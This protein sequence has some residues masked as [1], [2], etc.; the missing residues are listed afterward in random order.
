M[1]LTE[2]YDLELLEQRRRI[3]GMSKPK[4]AR[5]AGMSA[6]TVYSILE[7]GTGREAGVQKMAQALGISMDQVVIRGREIE[8][9]A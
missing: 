5:L 9:T 6:A 8:R 7:G 3:L 1:V 4:L 2:H